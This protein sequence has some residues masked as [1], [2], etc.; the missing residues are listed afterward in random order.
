MAS[1]RT[2]LYKNRANRKLI[3]LAAAIKIKESDILIVHR[4]NN[5]Q[6]K[7]HSLPNYHSRMRHPKQRI[8]KKLKPSLAL[9]EPY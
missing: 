7:I 6:I 3:F 5:D 1:R 4:G 9:T 2:D 8:L